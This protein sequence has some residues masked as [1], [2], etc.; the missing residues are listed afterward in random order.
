M[1]LA[2]YLLRKCNLAMHPMCRYNVILQ[3]IACYSTLRPYL[4]FIKYSSSINIMLQSH[5]SNTAKSLSDMIHNLFT[6][7]KHMLKQSH[8]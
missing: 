2:G 8:R 3:W 1:P 6:L 4:Q 7:E 5:D